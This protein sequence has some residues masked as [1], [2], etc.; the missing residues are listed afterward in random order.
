MSQ[1]Q[2]NT[3]STVD[4]W[5]YRLLIIL[6]SIVIPPFGL[7]F[8][9]WFLIL[10]VCRLR[11][12]YQDACAY[13]EEENSKIATQWRTNNLGGESHLRI[14]RTLTVPTTSGGSRKIVHEQVFHS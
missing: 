7:V 14:R 10:R 2:S 9:L 11:C 8:L 12:E 4:L 1:E 5:G 13:L 3:L 6:F